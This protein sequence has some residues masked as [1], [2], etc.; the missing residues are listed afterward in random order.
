MIYRV[1]ADAVI[2]MHLLF[3]MFAVAGGFV[4]VFWRYSPLVH[5]PVVVWGVVIAFSDLSCPLTPLENWL[6]SH[7][8]ASGYEGGFAAHY[9]GPIVHPV[10]ADVGLGPVA[11]I[12]LVAI[13]VVVYSLAIVRRRRSHRPA[14]PNVPG[15]AG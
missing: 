2:V 13:N 8:G 10:R 4:F 9:L 3:V 12:F 11:G 5:L 14:E 1:L 7:A 15:L 6:W